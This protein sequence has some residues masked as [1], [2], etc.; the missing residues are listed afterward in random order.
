MAHFIAISVL[1]VLPL[2]AVIVLKLQE[3]HHLKAE[4]RQSLIDRPRRAAENG[5]GAQKQSCCRGRK[6]LAVAV[7]EVTP[8]LTNREEEE[9]G[10]GEEEEEGEL[11]VTELDD[12]GA[13]T[14]RR[15]A[16]SSRYCL[17]VPRPLARLKRTGLLKNVVC[18]CSRC[19]PP[20]RRP[21]QGH[22]RTRRSTV[23]SSRPLT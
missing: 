14:V 2:A 16:P 15:R 10:A 18:V 11:E 8:R 17:Y 13:T 12:G 19:V 23:W 9:E 3:S 1:V 22:C 20:R 5:D 6:Q 7:V 21:T 4:H